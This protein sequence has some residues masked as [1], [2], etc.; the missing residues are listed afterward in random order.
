MKH[1]DLEGRKV[2]VTGG[3]GSLGRCLG[4]WLGACGASVLLMD[5]AAAVA[6]QGVAHVIGE[7]DLA[8]AAAAAAAFDRAALQLGGI[9]GLVNVAGGFAWETIEGGHLETWDRMY[10]MNLRSAVAASQAALKHL[11]TQP[12]PSIVNV[13]ALAA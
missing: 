11:S 4:T 7:V 10:T 3:L 13:G 9:D 8:D 5:R 12:A 1:A 6:V 2:V